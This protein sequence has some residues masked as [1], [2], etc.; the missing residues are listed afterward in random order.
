MN[1][2]STRLRRMVTAALFAAAI[3]VVTAYF[4][5]IPLPTGGYVH[6]GDTLIYLAACM[7][8]TPYAMFAASVG[9][10][11]ADLLTAPVWFIP[12]FIIKS[13][14]ALQ[15]TCKK[16]KILCVRNCIAACTTAVVSPVLYSVAF[17][18]MAGSWTLGTFVAQFWGTIGQA[19]V[20]GVLFIGLGYT[21]DKM[22]LKNR[23]LGK[24]LERL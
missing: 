16:E 5:H 8:P 11:I 24:Q 3:T 14:V 22:G 18:I 20:S 10:G 4:L 17:C 12:T 21:F 6:L 9:A 15:F 13:I 2:D 23:L 7:L 1:N 19:L